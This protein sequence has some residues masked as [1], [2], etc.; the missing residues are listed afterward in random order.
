MDDLAAGYQLTQKTV[1]AFKNS[2]TPQEE[3]Y[4]GRSAAAAVLGENPLFTKNRNLT[5]YINQIG[6][7]L[8]MCSPRPYLYNGYRF[9]ILDSPNNINAYATPGGHVFITTGLLSLC[10]NE[11]E[12]AAIIAHEIAHIVHQDAL[13]SISS[14][15]KAEAFK[16]IADFGLE[17]AG[18]R[19][20]ENQ[21][22]QLT[23]IFNKISSAVSNAILNGYSKKQEDKADSLAVMI[24]AAAGY[25]PSAMSSVIQ[26][27]PNELKGHYKSHS[28]PQARIQQVNSLIK[29][30]N[31]QISLNTERNKRFINQ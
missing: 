27:L 9:I 23:M 21:A 19:M 30:N 25:S 12:A 5:H 2:F 1:K 14:A 17:K 11:D 20:D 22:K 10:S 24:M 15:N 8:V 31:F 16:S 6:N 13:S 28:S 26:K 18:Q 7:T 29:M 4:I 3:Y